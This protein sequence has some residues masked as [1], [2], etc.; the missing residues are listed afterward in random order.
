MG[1]ALT[2]API[3]AASAHR[4]R[5]HHTSSHT[6]GSAPSSAMCQDVKAEEAGSSSIGL[7]IEKAMASGN[8]AA[9]KAAMLN[10]FNTDQG[11]VQKALAV[12]KTAPANVQAA[13]QNLLSY[14]QQIKND[15]A[16]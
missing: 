14:V 8:F 16:N 7:S 3:S 11:A 1:V 15:I 6:N 10:A 5:H 4:P 13:F 9:A 2:L 12:I